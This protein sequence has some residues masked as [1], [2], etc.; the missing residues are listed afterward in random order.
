MVFVYFSD[1]SSSG[2]VQSTHGFPQPAGSAKLSPRRSRGGAGK[3]FLRSVPNA[4]AH[5]TL[6]IYMS[7]AK[8]ECS[9]WT[10]GDHTGPWKWKR[11][12]E[13]KAGVPTNTCAREL[14]P[15]LIEGGVN[16]RHDGAACTHSETRPRGGE[17]CGAGTLDGVDEPLARS[18]LQKKSGTKVACCV[19]PVT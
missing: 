5:V 19:A 17:G 14:V 8:G 13:S 6:H 4:F 1:L 16:Q 12:K 18:A 7:R 11:S 10:Q 2:L 9:G 15:A 3:W